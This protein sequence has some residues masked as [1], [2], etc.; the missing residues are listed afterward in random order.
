M[1][2][3][4]ERNECVLLATLGIHNDNLFVILSGEIDVD[5]RKIIVLTR[6]PLYLETV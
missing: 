2:K 1:Q 4:F 5:F 6:V 3:V